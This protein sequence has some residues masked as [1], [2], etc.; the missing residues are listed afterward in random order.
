LIIPTRPSSVKLLA[1]LW[2]LVGA[3]SLLGGIALTVVSLHLP[4]IVPGRVLAVRSTL[5]SVAL[6]AVALISF[7][8]AY[9]SWTG[10][11]WAWIVSLAFALF[12]IVFSVLSLFMRPGLGEL[13][14]L[15][16]YLLVVYYLMQPCVR[17]FFGK[18]AV[19]SAG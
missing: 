18:G 8:L 19:P 4:E 1:V 2:I 10:K 12:G 14:G 13:I 15:V 3:L 16:I 7:G 5:T 6:V 17:S 11:A 9:G